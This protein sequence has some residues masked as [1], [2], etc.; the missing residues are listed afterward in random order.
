MV[1]PTG[2]HSGETKCIILA[3][4]TLLIRALAATCNVVIGEYDTMNAVNWGLI[5]I[6][7]GGLF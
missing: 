3:G 5:I 4:K 1:L 7:Q 2:R 6:T